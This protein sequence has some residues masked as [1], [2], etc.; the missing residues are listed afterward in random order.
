MHL[1]K[2]AGANSHNRS[3]LWSVSIGIL[4]RPTKPQNVCISAVFLKFFRYC[5]HEGYLC[6]NHCLKYLYIVDMTHAS[7][8]LH[9]YSFLFLKCDDHHPKPLVFLSY[10]PIYISTAILIYGFLLYYPTT[11]YKQSAV[12]FSRLQSISNYETFKYFVFENRVRSSSILIDSM[13]YRYINDYLCF[14]ENNKGTFTTSSRCEFAKPRKW[15]RRI[16]VRLRT[17]VL[18]GLLLWSTASI[19]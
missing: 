13:N 8:Q 11:Q 17:S 9:I 14:V 5:Q 3:T 18:V 15:W 16:W 4:S 6:P 2:I 12:L 10:L 1:N 7:L 19:P